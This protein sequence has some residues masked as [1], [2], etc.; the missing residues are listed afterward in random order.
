MRK[1]E[2]RKR[3]LPLG[4]AGALILALALLGG[5]AW[6]QNHSAS[7][8]EVAPSVILIHVNL[9]GSDYLGNSF[10]PNG[11]QPQIL[12]PD[13]V[14]DDGDTVVDNTAE[15]TIIDRGLDVC[16]NAMGT[17]HVIR[18]RG[19]TSTDDTT[20]S[21]PTWILQNGPGAPATTANAV[22]IASGACGSLAE[23]TNRPLWAPAVDSQEP[24]TQPAPLGLKDD[25]QCVVIKSTLP[26]E[27][28]VRLSF[29]QA[30][31]TGTPQ[32]LTTDPIVKEWDSLIDTV[33]LKSEPADMDGDTDIDVVDEHL[34]DEQGTVEND[35]VVFD[36]AIKSIRS[37][38]PVQLIEI[39]HGE[40][41][42]QANGAPGVTLHHPTQGAII[43]ATITSPRGCTY[44]TNPLLEYDTSVPPDGD[45]DVTVQP[46]THD[47]GSVVTGRSDAEGRF[48]GPLTNNGYEDNTD[49]VTGEPWAIRDLWLD[50][51]CEEQAT[52]TFTVDY[53]EPVGSALDLP[54]AEEITINWVTTEIAKQPQIRWAGEEIVLAKRWA[55]PDD[56]FPNQAAD[57]TFLPICPNAFKVAR[58][59]RLTTSSAGD[60][61]GGIPEI[62]EPFN[63]IDTVISMVDLDCVSRAMASSEDQGEGD[64]EATLHSWSTELGDLEDFT[65]GDALDMAQSELDR[66]NV[67]LGN[68]TITADE[69]RAD[70]GDEFLSLVN[71]GEFDIDPTAFNF[72]SIENKHAFLVW[73]IKIFQVKLDNILLADGV[74]RADHNSGTWAGEDP[75]TST[76]DTAE[77]LNVS[78]DALL[79]VTVKGW[80]RGGD[81]S[82]RPDVCIDMDGDGN[83]KT[84]ADATPPG[85]PYLGDTTHTGCADGPPNGPDKMLAGG[86]WVLPD[87]LPL[88]AGPSPDRLA[89][90]D[91][92]G[93]IDEAAS[94]DALLI[95]PKS[96]L[97]S[98]DPVGEAVMRPWVPCVDSSF[99]ATVLNPPTGIPDGGANDCPRKTIDPDGEITV[100]DAL[101][102][103]LKII[104]SLPDNGDTVVDPGETGFLK[105]ANKVDDV[106]ILSPYAS[107]MIPADPDIPP[108]VN[109]GGYDWDSWACRLPWFHSYSIEDVDG[110]QVVICGGDYGI[111]QGPYVFYQELTK[112]T[113]DN[114][115]RSMQFYTDNRGQ[116]FFFANGDFNLSFLG[117][118]TDLN[119]GTPDCNPDNV[120]G[121]SDI[122][123]IGD[124][125]YFRKHAAVESNP[126][127]KTWTW[128][129]FKRVTAERIDVNHTAI[130][131]HLK[132]RDGFCKYDVTVETSTAVANQKGEI[133]VVFSP[134]MHPVEGE[135]IEF[136]L[137]NK[138]L[139]SILSVS[140]SALFTPPHVPEAP[141][142]PLGEAMVTGWADGV[143]VDRD[144]A[145]ALAEDIRVLD[146]HDPSFARMDT[147]ITDDEC[148]AWIV[149]EHPA[150]VQP[151]VSVVFNDPEG[152]ITRHFPTPSHLVRLVNGWNDACYSGREQPIEDALAPVIDNVVAVYRL[153]NGEGTF[154]R[155]FPGRA[156]I[157]TITT[158]KPY[159]QL[160]ILMKASVDW[161]VETTALPTDV[162]LVKDWNSVCYA[163]NPKP[164]ADAT[165]SIAGDF[166]II[167][168]LASSDQ[169]WQRYVPGRP[170]LNTIGETLNQFTSVFILVTADSTT[171]VFDP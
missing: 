43:T 4:L 160:I 54:D 63:S 65:N 86:Y 99:D 133:D 146:G 135:E 67:E 77:T 165:A 111:E 151:D 141:H 66:L 97:D 62:F 5:G 148:Q 128:G 130:I 15:D 23:V 7:A 171:W 14:D 1:L 108:I 44:F 42:G 72:S 127:V 61:V 59:N 46:E 158:V 76:G 56:W 96:S 116:G 147:A 64:F 138:G 78:Q 122:T 92:M 144:D 161:E 142:V 91:V 137:N 3:Y 48:V 27:T 125:P 155:W 22:V 166:S 95:G 169:S 102:P 68:G 19:W 157:S 8:Q 41:V 49:P 74:G 60:L 131:A 40:H 28:V 52:I 115:T 53:P 129:G 84:G 139:A 149:V 35:P 98:H 13:G 159:D 145:I 162:A 32:T 105:E 132:D 69:L 2:T 51:I 73:W 117:C 58:Y 10:C 107:I 55:L 11:G 71:E 152:N 88:L 25:E 16:N 21:A 101:M 70:M 106:G 94:S 109:N 119:T 164:P 9:D 140:P 85:E 83:G 153:V 50:T 113:V 79:R 26:G 121:S 38:A 93:D 136:I 110:D 81:P 114:F 154:D 24:G 39:V 87:D 163:G 29:T 34:A 36:E 20:N 80:F 18:T 104:A 150:D 112:T 37:P 33:I 30:I 45:I 118:L 100:G 90:W 168:T 134:S 126:V 82:G 103:P 17:E 143:V 89:T 57:G 120:V 6:A 123:V 47:F 167:Y 124:Y 156:D 31:A 170:D 75:A 12:E